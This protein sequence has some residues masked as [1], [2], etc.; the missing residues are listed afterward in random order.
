MKWNYSMKQL[1]YGVTSTLFE[2][3]NDS[4]QLQ[5]AD[6]SSLTLN[7]VGWRKRLEKR[8][9][10]NAIPRFSQGLKYSSHSPI[11]AV[12]KI[13]I[14]KHFWRE[15]GILSP[16]PKAPEKAS[17]ICSS[18]RYLWKVHLRIALSYPGVL[19][20]SMI[21]SISLTDSQD[22]VNTLLMTENS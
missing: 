12:V 21:V 11:L 17:C 5:W 4:G 14:W 7:C 20:W 8:K 19:T 2:I 3:L 18:S 10:Q 6:A 13:N 9:G 15:Q 1:Y 22:G 16:N